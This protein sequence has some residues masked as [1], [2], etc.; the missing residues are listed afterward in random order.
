M[1]LSTDLGFPY[2]SSGKGFACN[3]G[4]TGDLGSIPGLGRSP[5]VR[6]GNP[7]QYTCLENPMRSLGDHSPWGHK[8]SDITGKAH[9]IMGF[10]ASDNSEMP[11][12]TVKGFSPYFLYSLTEIKLNV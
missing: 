9:T 1:F 11:F 6:H 3:A 10:P 7:L 4:N 12:S 5:G 2:D 8:E